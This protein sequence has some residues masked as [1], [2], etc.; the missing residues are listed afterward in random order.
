MT[1]VRAKQSI[2]KDERYR[3]I[4]S[5]CAR[6][7]FGILEDRFTMHDVDQARAAHLRA[8]M[9]ELGTVFIKLGQMLST[10]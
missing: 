3:E 1:V 5:I 2:S 4:V 10:R 7:G 6:N 8:A 9:E